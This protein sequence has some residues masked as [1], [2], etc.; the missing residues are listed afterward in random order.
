L[1]DSVSDT[2]SYVVNH[3]PFGPFPSFTN[4]LL[5]FTRAG[6]PANPR[7][8][9]TAAGVNNRQPVSAPIDPATGKADIKAG[10]SSFGPK[11]V[12]KLTVNGQ[13]VTQ[14]LVA[15]VG[16]APTVTAAQGTI[17]GQCPP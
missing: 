4:W 1:T 2:G 14:Q 7:A 17:A 11:Q 3:S 10:I 9:L 16:A 6:L 13:D 12:Q 5:Q 15:K 8:E